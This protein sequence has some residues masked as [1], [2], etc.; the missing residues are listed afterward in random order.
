VT[1]ADAAAPWRRA[2]RWAVAAGVALRLAVVLASGSAVS[3]GDA[4]AYLLTGR[5]VR[6][7][8]TFPE[9]RGL[10]AVMPPL[11]PLLVAAASAPGDDAGVVVLKLLNVAF[12]A[13][14][15]ALAARVAAGLAGGRWPA[16]AAW[17]VAVHPFLV[18]YARDVSTESAFVP[19]LLGS[20]LLA[21]RLARRPAVRPALALGLVLGVAALL[22]PASL[23]GSALLGLAVL[24]TARAPLLRRAEVGAAAALATALA[25]APWSVYA[26]ARWSEPILL[27]DT[28]GFNFWDGHHPLALPIARSADPAERERLSMRKDA[29]RRAMVAESTA[30]GESRAER[31]RRFLDDARRRMGEGGATL[32]WHTR[33]NLW[34]LW[35]PW[36]DPVVHGRLR[37]AAVA[38]FLVPLT[39]AG[40]LGVARAFRG[41]DRLLPLGA[42]ALLL[43]ITVG[44][45]A[46][47]GTFRYRFGHVDPILC[48]FAPAALVRRTPKVSPAPA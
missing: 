42:V 21:A 29:E 36:P 33:Q 8:G 26:S 48:A 39:L 38:A 47:V 31:S 4:D 45:A 11:Y 23:L 32:A 7:R 40:L 18:L 30:L 35:K 9:E 27:T 13:A 15:I 1:E 14:G 10:P 20:L 16:L 25:I 12:G 28:G 43:G 6:D 44:S 24:A 5:H 34:G 46:F 19:L 2:T 22:R 17:L 3:G 41:P 37:S